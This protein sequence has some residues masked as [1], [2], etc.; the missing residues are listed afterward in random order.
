M[1]YF[2]LMVAALL[3]AIVLCIYVFR[4]DRVDKEPITLLLRLFFLG[5]ISCL[6]AVLLESFASGIVTAFFGDPEHLPKLLYYG[7]AAAENFLG[8]ALIEEGC[9]WAM[10]LLATRNS[11]HFDSLFDGI[12]YAVF[13]SLGFAAFE[14]VGYAVS[15]GMS[16]ALVRAFT[17]I[18]GHMFFGVMMGYY[19]SWWHAHKKAQ[20]YETH[21]H[22]IGLLGGTGTQFHP[23]SLLFKSLAYPMLIHG[24]Y[25]LT[26]TLQTVWSTLMFFA[27][28]LVLYVHSFRTVRKMSA[29]DSKNFK[30]A[31]ALLEKA[32]P[33]LWAKTAPQL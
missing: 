10:L 26:C 4:K 20:E 13:V 32:Y 23:E 25:D 15:F 14:N 27:F 18:P 2:S 22:A 33:G 12:V 6:P 28:L 29:M 5:A 30:I 21:F 9:K 31:F 1:G 24:L 19:Y 3:P 16:T 17:S 7:Y 8:I 11:K